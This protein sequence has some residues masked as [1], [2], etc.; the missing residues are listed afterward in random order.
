MSI[1]ADLENLKGRLKNQDFSENEILAL[2]LVG[3]CTNSV[4]WPCSI[5]GSCRWLQE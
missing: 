5:R 3:L 4:F 2:P 1:D